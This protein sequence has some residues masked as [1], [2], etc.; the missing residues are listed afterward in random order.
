MLSL[1]LAL[2]SV[3]PSVAPMPSQPQLG[4]ALTAMTQ[5]VA[6]TDRFSLSYPNHW[7][8][9]QNSDNY[10]MIYNQ[11]PP[12]V[13]GDVAPTYLIKTDASFM[14]T[15]L[16]EAIQ[17]YHD[18]PERIRQIEEVVVNGRL[19]VRIWEASDGWDFPN[20]LITYIPIS[21]QEVAYVASYYSLENQFAEAAILQVHDS[22]V[23]F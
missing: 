3:I 14:T 21:D 7:M 1:L 10:V 18:E 16:R 8:V 9:T 20:T 19:G 22:L 15:T 13:G 12:T 2:G 17:P 5:R 6:T 11:T 4:C 23:L